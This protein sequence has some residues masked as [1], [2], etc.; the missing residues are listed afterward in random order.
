MTKQKIKPKVKPD[1]VAK[2][3]SKPSNNNKRIQQVGLTALTVTLGALNVFNALPAWAGS[4]VLVGGNLQYPATGDPEGISI[5]QKVIDLAGGTNNA[6]LGIFTTASSSGESAASN[7]DLW[8]EDFNEL[9][10]TDVEWIP[11]HIDNCASARNDPALVAQIGTRNG[12]FF[13]GGDQSYITQCLF[14]ENAAQGKRMASPV[15][16]ALSKQFDAGAVIAGTSAGTA[17]QTSSPMITEGESYEALVNGSTALI[18]TPPLVRD[19]YYNPLGGLG[20]FEYGLT[21]SHFSE[22]GRQ[23]RT[24][25]LASDLGIPTVYGVDENTALVVT[26]P[27]TPEV[28]MEVIGQ[29]GVFI[30]DLTGATVDTSSDYWSISGVSATYLTEGDQ[31]NPLSGT[32]TFAP[33]KTAIS[34]QDC[35]RLP[36]TQDIF[37]SLTPEPPLDQERANPRALTDTAIRLFNSCA[38]SAKGQSYET[39]P[40]PYIVTLTESAEAGSQGF[41]GTNERGTQKTSFENLL[42]TIGPKTRPV[43]EPEVG[44]GLLGLAILSAVSQLK[45]NLEQ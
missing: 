3:I 21:D 41:V 30:S 26:D 25:R 40:I 5:Y 13:G 17:V 35:G 18:G 37:S 23:G 20:F 33:W 43:P 6:K 8:I 4:L 31:Y 38:T 11:I 12:F 2:P 7:A 14:D 39:D 9:G 15:F 28:Q 22:R 36:L 24:I 45:R 10:I 1:D 16:E 29:G 32:A 34:N 44:F 42:I 27:S 19:L